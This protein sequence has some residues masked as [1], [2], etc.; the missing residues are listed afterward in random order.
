MRKPI[1][2]SSPDLP[3]I[4]EVLERLGEHV[5]ER[6]GDDDAAGER[7]QGRQGMREPQA[8]GAAGEGRDHG[9]DGEGDH[10][11][12]HRRE[13]DNHSHRS[14][15]IGAVARAEQSTDWSRAGDRG[16]RASRADAPGARGARWSNCSRDRTAA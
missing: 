14:A 13:N 1:P 9:G 10:D 8:Q 11:Q 3:R 6:D 7:H 12:F 15:M 2:A 16:A 5:E 4:V